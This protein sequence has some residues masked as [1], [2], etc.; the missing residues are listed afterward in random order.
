MLVAGDAAALLDHWSREGISYALRSGDLAGRAA[1]RVLAAP[2]EEAVRAATDH[3]GR[4]IDEVLG[5]EMRA[6]ATLMRVFAR[7]PALVHTALTR[8]PPMWRRLD[9]Y[10]AGHSGVAEIMTT[11]LARAAAALGTA[12]PA[13]PAGGPPHG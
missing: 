6:S 2:D 8:L 10:I 1:T 12:L 7:N 11:P 5:A 9:A 4:R 13:R 3:Y